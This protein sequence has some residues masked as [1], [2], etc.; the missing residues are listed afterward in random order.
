MPQKEENINRFIDR[1]L[2]AQ[3][4]FTTGFMARSLVQATMPHRRL[5]ETIFIRRNGKYTLTMQGHPDYGLP[6]GSI[7]RLLLSWITT[8]AVRRKQQEI[9]LGD[10]MSQFMH[11]IGFKDASGGENGSI[12]SLKDQ[13]KRL[14]TCSISCVLDGETRF[15]PESFFP[16]HKANV[17]WDVKNPSQTA[18]FSSTITLST[19]FYN[20]I[21]QAPVAFRLATL[22]LLKKS[23]L[24][25]D[26]YIWIT[27]RNSYARKPS[28]ISWEALQLQFGAGYPTTPEGQRDFKK[29]FIRT[30]KKVSI[31]YPE[32][33]KLRPER[34]QLIF[35]PGFP[36]IPKLVK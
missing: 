29:N 9:D 15:I 3:H 36:D 7:P 21:I 19:E 31:A 13:M 18:L 35:V 30:L 24:A 25:I 10:S 34:D 11:A 32:A 12:T 23:P 22:K 4:D 8:E 1:A 33:A 5:K 16:I 2:E 6:F 27:Y 17:W 26:M 20:E 28:W 14:F